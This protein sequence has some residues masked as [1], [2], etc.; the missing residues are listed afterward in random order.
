MTEA[1]V[2]PASDV[3]QKPLI[4]VRAYRTDDREQVLKIYV[5]AVT[6]YAETKGQKK[7]FWLN[8]IENGL[9]TDMG[10]IEG[11]YSA[12]AGQ[13][14]VATTVVDQ[15][16]IVIGTVGL[17]LKPDNEAELRRMFVAPEYQ[18]ADSKNQDTSADSV[19]SKPVIH[20]RSFRPEDLEQV[21]KVFVPGV[22]NYAEIEGQ[23]KRFWTDYIDNTLKTDLG[24]VEDTYFGS[25]GHFWVA[26]TVVNNQEVIIGTVGLEGKPNRECEMRRMS[27]MPEYRRYGVGRLLVAHLERWAEQSGF[28]KVWL[29]TGRVMEQACRFYESLGYEHTRSGVYSPEHPYVEVLDYEKCFS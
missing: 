11:T 24:N 13:F 3:Q 19:A 9:K 29:T 4:Q 8:Y 23:V 2:N 12:P 26:T 7:E 25:G 1:T 17:E 6:V 14:W 28:S 27:V 10:D 16:E 5:A 20:V 15:R 22:L 21:L 18:R